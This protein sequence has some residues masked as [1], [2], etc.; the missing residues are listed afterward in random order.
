MP[1]KLQT[2]LLLT[3]LKNTQV[4]KSVFAPPHLPRF[5]I[6]VQKLKQKKKPK[7]ILE[8]QIGHTLIRMKQFHFLSYKDMR[9]LVCLFL[10]PMSV[11]SS[12]PIT[13]YEAVTKA[14]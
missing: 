2:F 4:I 6:P 3:M 8:R 1:I 13:L 7:T 10:W 12:F 9:F 5:F 11:S 14:A